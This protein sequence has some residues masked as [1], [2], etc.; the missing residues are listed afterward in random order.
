MIA[1]KSDHIQKAQEHADKVRGDLDRVLTAATQQATEAEGQNTRAQ[2][3]ADTA[4]EL[5]TNIRTT[6]GSAETD[7]AAITSALETATESAAQTKA[8]ADKAATVEERIAAYEKRLAEL[9]S[10]CATQLQT[11]TGLLPGATSAGLAHAFNERR[12]SFLN[13]SKRWQWLFVGSVCA[14]VLLTAQ[15]LWHVY[16]TG[17]TLTY[18]ELLRLW[19]SRL[20]VAGALVWLAMYAS[21]ESALAKRLEEDYGYKSAIAST[22]QGFHKQMSEIGTAAAS[23]LPLA[24]LCEDT[25]TTIASPPGRIYDKHQL[26]VSPTADLTDAVKNV[27]DLVK[28][29]A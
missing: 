18:D 25:L 26:T 22:F 29:G 13:P 19:L 3:A 1:T 4:A 2:S 17:T 12:K 24:K 23:N 11:I 5:L 27:G 16:Q 21:R 7:A 15:G 9:E 10:Q 28:S 6:K 8:L 20:P 14:I